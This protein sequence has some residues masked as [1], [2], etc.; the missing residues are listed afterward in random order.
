V[1]AL[2]LAA[3]F[4]RHGCSRRDDVGIDLQPA[5]RG[6]GGYRACQG[7]ARPRAASQIQLRLARGWAPRPGATGGSVERQDRCRAC[8]AWYGGGPDGGPG[9]SV[10]CGA[11]V[12]MWPHRSDIHADRLAARK[13]EEQR[14]LG[15]G[16][17]QKGKVGPEGQCRV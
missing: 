5:G 6:R 16:G 2:P 11:C 17:T 12:V 9:E 8:A 10:G 3:A 1:P 13:E 14:K 4:G 7:E 15:G